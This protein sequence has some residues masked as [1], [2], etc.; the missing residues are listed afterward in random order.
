M[1]ICRLIDNLFMV[2]ERTEKTYLTNL[3]LFMFTKKGDYFT[4]KP[5]EVVTGRPIFLYTPF[6]KMI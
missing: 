1:A 5:R 6:I 4:L 2:V 3:D